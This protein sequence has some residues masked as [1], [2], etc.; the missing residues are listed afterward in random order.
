ML[1]VGLQDFLN[2]KEQGRWWIVGSAWQKQ[3]SQNNN[4]KKVEQ[5][6]NVYQTVVS[7]AVLRG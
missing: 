6:F 3:T 1:N 4:T 5:K 2:V 7:Y